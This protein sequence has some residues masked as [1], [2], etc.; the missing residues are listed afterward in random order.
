M[1]VSRQRIVAGSQSVFVDGIQLDHVQNVGSTTTFNTEDIFNLGRLA[2]IDVVDDIPAVA[3]TIDS[4]EV[5]GIETV[6]RL[7]RLRSS[8]SHL[9]DPTSTSGFDGVALEDFIA[10]DPGGAALWCPTQSESKLGVETDNTI[11]FT[12]FMGDLFVN[13]IELSYA[14]GANNGENYDAETD[15]KKWLMNSGKYVSQVKYSGGDFAGSGWAAILPTGQTVMGDASAPGTVLR[16]NRPGF[17]LTNSLQQAAIEV[18]DISASQYVKIP[19]VSGASGTAKSTTQAAFW[20]APN[21][22][23][24]V[25]LPSGTVT[26][27]D[28]TYNSAAIADNDEFRMVF[29]ATA[30]SSSGTLET[31]YNQYFNETL[32]SG[33]KGAQRQGGVEVFLFDRETTPATSFDTRLQGVTITADLTREPLQ[34]LGNLRAFSR[35]ATPPIPVTVTIESLQSNIAALA[36]IAGKTT[37]FNNNTQIDVDIFDI[38]S[39]KTFCCGVYVYHQTDEDAGGTH[40][41]RTWKSTTTIKDSFGNSRTY[42]AGNRELPQKIILVKGLTPT[43]EAYS[44]AVGSNA[45]QGISFRAS[46]NLYWIDTRDLTTAQFSILES[47]LW[48]IQKA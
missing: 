36:K 32:V 44:L 23:T 13:N 22:I 12:M 28:K 46:T 1:P 31:G 21:G 9:Q 11:D 4:T 29:A 24:F 20:K 48:N 10:S 47:V 30:Y 6:Q 19:I 7:A 39:K 38:L 35:V 8:S 14:V 18:Y 37:N 3:V 2:V 16:G 26:D 5:N 34:Q 25:E 42:T 15:N 17:L 40:S 43:E 45:T 27:G 41:N 33:A